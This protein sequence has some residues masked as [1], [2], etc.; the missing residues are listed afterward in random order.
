MWRFG[1]KATVVGGSVYFDP[2][3]PSEKFF[4]ERRTEQG[5]YDISRRKVISRCEIEEVDN[6]IQIHSTNYE[7]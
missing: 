7:Q 4:I 5:N 2:T 6:E 3:R 1:L